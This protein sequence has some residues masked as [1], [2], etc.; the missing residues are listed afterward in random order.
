MKPLLPLERT[1]SHDLWLHELRNV[2]S[3]A[4]VATNM[5]R[6]FAHADPDLAAE[7][8]CEAEVAL[9]ACRELLAI[10]GEH[11]RIDVP[12]AAGEGT[13]GIAIGRER[14]R[15]VGEEIDLNEQRR[16]A[17]RMRLAGDLPVPRSPGEPRRLDGARTGT[18]G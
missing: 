6:R 13:P 10:A 7:L 3:T 9:M 1:S 17:L 8:L 4:C 18:D 12:A 11:V 5:G 2:V 15:T 14:R 16:R